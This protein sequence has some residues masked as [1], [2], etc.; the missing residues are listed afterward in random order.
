MWHHIC[1]LLWLGTS[2]R[3]L[4]ES[5]TETGSREARISFQVADKICISEHKDLNQFYLGKFWETIWRLHCYFVCLCTHRCYVP[6]WETNM[7]NL[8]RWFN[9]GGVDLQQQF[10]I[11]SVNHQRTKQTRPSASWNSLSLPQLRLPPRSLQI[12]E[13]IGY[14][15]KNQCLRGCTQ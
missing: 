12:S 9:K 7:D 6:L 1:L 4:P 10:P 14:K 15:R 5:I 13:Y 8:N 2:W 3:N 11:R